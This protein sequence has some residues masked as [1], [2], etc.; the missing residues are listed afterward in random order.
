MEIESRNGSSPFRSELVFNGVDEGE[1]DPDRAFRIGFF[2]GRGW[3]S[4]AGMGARQEAPGEISDIRLDGCES[5]IAGFLSISS[6]SSTY[7]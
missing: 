4:F 1:E 3:W 6:Q 5:G 7:T 2:R